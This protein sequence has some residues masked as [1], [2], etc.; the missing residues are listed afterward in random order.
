MRRLTLAVAL[1]AALALHAQEHDNVSLGFSANRVYQFGEIDTVNMFNGNLVVRVPIGLQYPVDEATSLQ[2]GLIYNSKVWDYKYELDGAYGDGQYH[3]RA[4]PNFRSNA[5]LGWRLSLGRLLPP[6]SASMTPSNDPQNP[7]GWQY[8]SPSGD[9]HDFWTDLHGGSQT[10]GMAVAPLTAYTH[11]STYLRLRLSSS[12]T[13]YVDFPDGSTHTFSLL[14]GDWHL[15]SIAGPLGASITIGYSFAAYGTVSQWTISDSTGARTHY[16]HFR[17][18]TMG[19][20]DERGQIADSIDLAAPPDPSTGAAR[21]ALYQF[22]Y[23]QT[24]VPRG[25][26]WSFHIDPTHTE[27][28]TLSLPMLSTISLPDGSAWSFGYSD[29]SSGSNCDQGALNTL[30]LPTGGSHTYAYTRWVFPSAALCGQEPTVDLT[31]GVT[32]RTVGGNTWRYAHSYS[33]PTQVNSGF[34]PSSQPEGGGNE[35]NNQPSHWIRTAALSPDGIRTDHY[36]NGWNMTATDSFGGRREEYAQPFTRARWN[37]GGT[38]EVASNDGSSPA[39]YLSTELFTGCGGF[40]SGG[41]CTG[42]PLLARSTFLRYE[43]DSTPNEILQ[44]RVASERTRFDDDCSPAPCRLADV[45]RSDFDTLGHYRTESTDGTFDGNNVFATFTN[46]NPSG[47]PASGWN[48]GTYTEKSST[49]DG[50]TLRTLTSFD[51]LSGFLQSRRILAGSSPGATDLVSTF[52]R[53]TSGTAASIQQQDSGGDLATVYRSNFTYTAGVLT[54]AVDVDPAT[55]TPL[56]FL[57]IDR[58]LDSATG[59]VIA[60][61]DS[62][63]LATQYKYDTSGRIVQLAPPGLGTTSFSYA[64]VNGPLRARVDVDATSSTDGSEHVRSGYELDGLGRLARETRDMPGGVTATRDTTYD[65]MSRVQTQSGWEQGTPSH[66]TTFAYDAFGRGTTIIPPDGSQHMVRM[67]YTGIRTMTRTIGNPTSRPLGGIAT[68]SDSFGNPVEEPAQKS[69]TYDRLGRL[70]SVVEQSGAGNTPFTTAYAY[71]PGGQLALVAVGMQFRTFNYD[72]RGLLLS[73][74]HPEASVV[75]ENYDAR[76]HATHTTSGPLA[77]AYTFD[78][79]RRL[80][81]ATDRN[82]GR[83]LTSFTY[84][85]ANDCSLSPCDYRLGKLVSAVR[86]NYDDNGVDQPVTESYLYSGRGG[87]VSRRDTTVRQLNG[88]DQQFRLQQTWDGA[89]RLSTLTYPARCLDLSCNASTSPRS[90]TYHYGAGL[91][92]SIDGYAP[93]VSY[94]ANGLLATLVHSN[95]VSDTWAADSSGMAR[96]GDIT[97]TGGNLQSVELGPYAYDADGNLTRVGSWQYRYDTVSRLVSAASPG[98]NNTWAYDPFGNMIA[99]G[100][101]TFSGN[102]FGAYSVPVPVDISTNRLHDAAVAAVDDVATY[103]GAGNMIQA[104][105]PSSSGGRFDYRYTW[106][107][108]GAMRTLRAGERTLLDTGADGLVKQRYLYTA[109]GERIGLLDTAPGGIARSRWSLRG[110]DNALLSTFTEQSGTWSWNEDQIWRGSSLLANESP[111]GTL[112]YHLDHLGSPR[113]V[114]TTSGTLAGR[115]DFAPF[116]A[117]GTTGAGA[118]QFTAHE[119][120]RLQTATGSYLDSLDYMHARYYSA[121]WGRFLSVDPELDVKRNLPEP[122]RWS[123]YA[124]VV[125]NPMNRTDPNGKSDLDCVPASVC[126]PAVKAQVRSA[127]VQALKVSAVVGAAV[128]IIRFA[129]SA[130]RALVSWA[131]GNPNQATHVT[132]AL[133][134]PPGPSANAGLPDIAEQLATAERVGTGLLKSDPSHRA[135]SFG[136]DAVARAGQSFE[137]QGGDGVVRTLIQAPGEVSGNKGIFEYIINNAGQVTHQRF[138]EDGVITGLPNQK[139]P[140]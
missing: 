74:I 54:S 127:Q 80:L 10:D 6:S 8:E 24:A 128:L 132:E 87:R 19:S 129:P 41:N 85:T 66:L 130:A 57:R 96:P 99:Y 78:P 94:Q 29:G 111:T 5:G 16:I 108:L 51:P 3:E 60:A 81:S 27:P 77:L 45:N 46:Y 121:G 43:Y 37:A 140:V 120:D 115:Q 104:S 68:G 112:H 113:V 62:A 67:Q 7:H 137:L 34:C 70:A 65:A 44:S 58:S 102:V 38:A 20:T 71:A 69:E 83:L 131:I 89:G 14:N 64:N 36:F 109:D 73:E 110:L 105:Y 28:L 52:T 63:G 49:T 118:L 114:T 103:D 126:T 21:R 125:N 53:G 72:K 117:G 79:A 93:S 11:D 1:L 40:D 4:Y 2:L 18:S 15:T 91:L 119:R 90:V 138:I 139:P 135:A 88:N 134:A 95:G 106:D 12:T 92:T 47:A 124:Y 101:R 116:G 32:T 75:Y 133:L 50:I 82:S 42:F 76:G 31:P 48:L 33:Q 55:G 122:Q 9:E 86:H 123:R 30:T 100:G 17:A 13:S 61:R 39:R 26:G 23:A 136:L 25:C 98:I 84:G 35:P 22:N 97:I 59:L 56:P 107:A